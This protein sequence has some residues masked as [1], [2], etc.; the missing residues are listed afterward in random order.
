MGGVFEG[1]RLEGCACVFVFWFCV[2]LQK[3]NESTSICLS[4]SSKGW[5]SK[6]KK[7]VRGRHVLGSTLKINQIKLTQRR[8]NIL[9]TYDSHINYYFFAGQNKMGVLTVHIRVNISI[10][11]WAKHFFFTRRLQL[12]RILDGCENVQSRKLIQLFGWYKFFWSLSLIK[13]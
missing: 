6:K 2:A 3:D 8:S 1:L 9:Y 5:G 4:R 13:N 7:G 11:A 12:I 10:E